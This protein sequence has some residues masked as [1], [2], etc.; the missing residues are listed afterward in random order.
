MFY[1]SADD[2]RYGREHWRSY[3]TATGTALLADLNSTGSSAPAE[4]TLLGSAVVF[5]ANDGTSGREL[6]SLDATGD[7]PLL[8]MTAA[9]PQRPEGHTGATSL[10]F[11][12]EP[13]RCWHPRSGQFG[14]R[15]R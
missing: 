5:S 7:L 8:A 4:L 12:V 6:W 3:G 13:R 1:F 2:G 14:V 9:T 10:R 11:V 15:A